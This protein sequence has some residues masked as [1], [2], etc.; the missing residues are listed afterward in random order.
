[1]ARRRNRRW[2]A[3]GLLAGA[4]A[5]V[6]FW[7]VREL[8]PMPRGPALYVRFKRP[9]PLGS[10]L[11][12]LKRRGV[13]RDPGALRLVGWLFRA[14]R[15]VAVGTYYLEPGSTYREI[16][17]ALASPIRRMMRMPETNW[18]RRDSHLLE[19][20]RV[21]SAAE[22]MDDVNHPERFKNVVSFPLPSKTL[23]GYLLPD[24]YDFP[25]L[26]G[27]RNVIE[28][29]LTSFE[30]KVWEPLDEPKDLARIVT[31]AS[32]IELEAGN[33]HDRPLIASVIEN[34]LKKGMPLQIDA[35]IMYGLGKWRKL[36]LKDYKEVKSP[37][38][39]YL[40]KG[41]PPTPICS[42]SLKSI[43]AAMNPAKTDYLFYV[44]L[45]DGTTHFS[46]TFEEHKK[47]VRI[48]LK[49]LAALSKKGKT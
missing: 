36:T 29:R 14:P 30:E 31:I 2:I 11:Y 42:P 45:P 17:R 20:A 6:W 12:E 19:Q 16:L 46:K 47:K 49:A 35:G 21:T 41:L 40:H 4:V 3:L 15:V 26:F 32:L 44:A 34:R 39:L 48:R 5:A 28:R 24:T 10:A 43:Q 18:A 1:M 37:Y 23:E 7:W 33:D 38:N 13:V 22:Y 25:P 8:A 27:A 9:T